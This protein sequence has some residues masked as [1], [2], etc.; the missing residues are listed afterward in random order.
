M[1]KGNQPKELREPSQTNLAPRPV[2]R[3]ANSGAVVQSPAAPQPN[4]NNAGLQVATQLVN[5]LELSGNTK[6]K[7]QQSIALNISRNGQEAVLNSAQTQMAA[8]AKYRKDTLDAFAIQG[9]EPPEELLTRLDDM[10]KVVGQRVTQSMMDRQTQAQLFNTF[11]P[12]ELTQQENDIKFEIEDFVRPV[13]TRS[14]QIEF[15]SELVSLQ[16]DKDSLRTTQ[17]DNAVKVRKENTER[18][19]GELDRIYPNANASQIQNILASGAYR[20][21]GI[22]DSDAG[23]WARDKLKAD[24]DAQKIRAEIAAKR[25][26]TSAGRATA[27]Q[28]LLDLSKERALGNQ[29]DTALRTLLT[30]LSANGGEYDM[31]SGVVVNATDVSAHIDKRQKSQAG[32]NE[33]NAALTASNVA[34]FK[35]FNDAVRVD[36][37]QQWTTGDASGSV[38]QQHQLF[39]QSEEERIL[40]TFPP[41][42][43]R[44]LALAAM[45]SEAEAQFGEIADNAVDTFK[46]GLPEHEIPLLAEFEQ[47]GSISL[48]QNV[49]KTLATDPL[50]IDLVPQDSPF[51]REAT[52]FKGMMSRFASEADFGNLD[53][54]I[55]KS[56]AIREDSAAGDLAAIMQA[57]FVNEEG[58]NIE[59]N[60]VALTNAEV[61]RQFRYGTIQSVATFNKVKHLITEETPVLETFAGSNTKGVPI[62]ENT[63]QVSEEYLTQD[64]AVNYLKIMLELHNNTRGKDITEPAF[65]VQAFVSAV[66]RR[67]ARAGLNEVPDKRLDS[68]FAE[69]KAQLLPQ[70]RE[71]AIVSAL[72]QGNTSQ[73]IGEGINAQRYQVSAEQDINVSA[74]GAMYEDVMKAFNDYQIEIAKLAEQGKKQGEINSRNDERRNELLLR[75]NNS[76]VGTLNRRETRTNEED[77]SVRALLN[78]IEQADAWS[79]NSGR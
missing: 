17:I 53:S 72:S 46:A 26:T 18:S 77:N 36:R 48:T 2:L 9:A 78:L 13:A 16:Q 7:V 31:G 64:K 52:V 47:R 68:A 22:S 49:A 21:L 33:I 3:G 32:T 75:G 14:K 42:Q 57:T 61:L 71:E 54:V 24:L 58:D 73:I 5:R 69:T 4:A 50:S 1:L 70:T 67:P 39:L 38:A 10:E 56:I 63:G 79:P 37:V 35:M 12:D 60:G 76:G 15:Q 44:E 62:F 65:G 43:Q 8:F 66:T 41:G 55:D 30:E 34:Q 45:N 29:S 28:K 27:Q 51:R 74:T 23:L 11:N 25:Q 40:Q 19:S 20:S 6:R 59:R